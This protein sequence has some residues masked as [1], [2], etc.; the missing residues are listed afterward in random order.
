MANEPT[1]KPCPFCGSVPWTKNFFDGFFWYWRIGCTKCTAVIESV[2]V[3]EEPINNAHNA[4]NR[5][6]ADGTAK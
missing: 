3:E 2:S 1:L 6:V 4:W 5:R